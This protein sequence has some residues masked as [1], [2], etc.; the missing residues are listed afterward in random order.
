[1]VLD[2]GT[3]GL[4]SYREQALNALPGAT[5][6]SATVPAGG[7][8]IPSN[9]LASTAGCPEVGYGSEINL[10]EEMMPVRVD[11]VAAPGCDGMLLEL[12]RRLSEL[13]VAKTVRTGRATF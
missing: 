4:R 12:T 5:A 11:L 13:G 9:Y 8:N 2:M 6:L 7:P 3:G 10:Q 1:M